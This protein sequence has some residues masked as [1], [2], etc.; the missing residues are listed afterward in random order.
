MIRRPP[1]ATRT[2]T[3]FPYTT[4]FRSQPALAG[5]AGVACQPDAQI[6][7]I[8]RPREI[9]RQHLLLL[10]RGG[11]G[12]RPDKHCQPLVIAKFGKQAR[13]SYHFALLEPRSIE[14][15]NRDLRCRRRDRKSPRLTSSH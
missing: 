2:D 10:G 6:G 5:L 4:L 9:G 1:R 3:L 14:R 13:R 15:S 7:P 12:K 11:I 8:E